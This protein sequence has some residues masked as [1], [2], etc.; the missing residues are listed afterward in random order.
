MLRRYPKE[1]RLLQPVIRLVK[2]SNYDAVEQ[3]KFSRKKID[4]LFVPHDEG[5]WISVELKINDWKRALWQATVNSGVADKSYVA[6]WESSAD[7]ALHNRALFESCG[8]GIIKVSKTEA[9]FVLHG[10]LN[11]NRTRE[12]Q[13]Q[14]LRDEW[15]ARRKRLD[16]ASL[17]PA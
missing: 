2:A 5:P 1:S 11:E 10:E 17:L 7:R 12:R 9:S 6:L 14:L 16:S 4:V 8:V 15:P 3:A 13:Q